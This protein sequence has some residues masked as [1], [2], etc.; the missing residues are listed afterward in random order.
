MAVCTAAAARAEPLKIRIGW[1]TV[2]TSLA[3][4]LFARPELAPHLG[5]AYVVEPHPLQRQLADDDGTGVGRSRHRRAESYSSFAYAVQ[6]GHMEDLRIIADEIEDGVSGYYSTEY[7]VLND[8]PVHTVEDMKGK[9]A[10]DQRHRRRHRHRLAGH[11]A[12]ARARGQARLHHHRGELC[13]HA[14]A[15]RRPQGRPRHA[16]R[17]FLDAT[18]A[19]IAHPLFHA[20]RT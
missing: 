17:L 11:A 16:H 19:A 5:K 2:P 1:I 7:M 6:N 20:A 18:A 14:G 8:G 4:I 10:R 13:Q 9:V 12:P 15:A 3:P